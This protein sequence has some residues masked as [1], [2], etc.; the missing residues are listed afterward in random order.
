MY[1]T[2]QH[3]PSE[4]ITGALVVL[5]AGFMYGRGTRGDKSNEQDPLEDLIRPPQ[6]NARVGGTLVEVP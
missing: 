5:L 2:W 6:G 3:S 1:Q 4:V